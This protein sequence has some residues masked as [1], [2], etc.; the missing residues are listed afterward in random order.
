MQAEVKVCPECG[1]YYDARS[2][3]CPCELIKEG[4][5]EIDILRK[6]LEAAQTYLEFTWGFDGED[7]SIEPNK[8]I[9][10]IRTSLRRP[11][12]DEP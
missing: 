9:A 2:L 10:L 5:D 4:D 3:Q 8:T 12:V 11:L 6:A 7:L 1:S